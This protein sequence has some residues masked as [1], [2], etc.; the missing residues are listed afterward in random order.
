M[1]W[2]IKSEEVEYG[3]FHYMH[4]CISVYVCTPHACNAGGG[5]MWALDA[6]ELEWKMVMSCHMDPVPLRKGGWGS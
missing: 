3:F 6:L 4:L 2:L 1:T 5:Q